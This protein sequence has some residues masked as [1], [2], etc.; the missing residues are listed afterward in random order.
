MRT[1]SAVFAVALLALLVPGAAS[2][3]GGSDVLAGYGQAGTFEA[4]VG[5][6]SGPLGENP[7]GNLRTVL[8]TGLPEFDDLYTANTEVVCLQVSGN[9]AVAVG[10]ARRDPEL[11]SQFIAFGVLV[12]DNGPPGG[13]MPDRQSTIATVSSTEEGAGEG[14]CRLPQIFIAFPITRGNYTVRDSTP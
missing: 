3:Q 7:Q 12:E 10:P 8:T 5:A 4:S 14:S 13:P 11:P 2:A 1:V 9:R 6:R